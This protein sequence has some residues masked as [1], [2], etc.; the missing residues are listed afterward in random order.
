MKLQST[1]NHG[2]PPPDAN[3]NLRPMTAGQSWA[4]VMD[5]RQTHPP[6]G[7]IHHEQA[8]TAMSSRGT[9]LIDLQTSNDHAAHPVRVATRRSHPCCLLSTGGGQ[10]RHRRR[11]QWTAPAAHA[12]RYLRGERLGRALVATSAGS[13]RCHGPG[14]GL[15][16]GTAP[17]LRGGSR[18]GERP[19]PQTSVPLLFYPF[20]AKLCN[21]CRTGEAFWRDV[22]GPPLGPDPERSPSGA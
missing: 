4:W 11:Q 12:R 21:E 14:S 9:R 22:R 3:T 6:A 15:D 10:C 1:L 2:L 7:T 5:L 20:S 8:S 19:L 16:S 13:T 18:V 17:S